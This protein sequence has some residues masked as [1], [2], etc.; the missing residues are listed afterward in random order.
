MKRKRSPRASPAATAAG[1]AAG[2]A[3]ACSPSSVFTPPRP[4]AA[5]AMRGLPLLAA[6]VPLP[7]AAK[8]ERAQVQAPQ[9]EQRE[10]Q[11]APEVLTEPVR[12][13]LP[14][15]A[16]HLSTYL[17]EC[18]QRL[19]MMFSQCEVLARLKVDDMARVL[20]RWVGQGAAVVV[21]RC[22]ARFLTAPHAAGAPC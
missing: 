14:W 8:Q 7:S 20:F 17:R 13:A 19:S 22:H 3:P 1:T 15:Q 18:L 6:G 10:R 2:A 16:A 12:E 9:Q 21:A 4:P 11:A 5:T